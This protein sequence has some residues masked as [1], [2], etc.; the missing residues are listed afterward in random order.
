MDRTM[1]HKG[2]KNAHLEEIEIGWKQLIRK[3]EQD[4]GDGL[5]LQAVLFLI[6][7]QELG[8]GNKKYTKDQKLEVFHVA[9]CTLLEPYGYYTF[10]GLDPDGY[11][12]WK[13]LENLPSLTAGQQMLLMKQAI[14]DY[15]SALF[16]EG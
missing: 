9:I 11:P 6:G 13:Q 14:L 1:R 16:Q 4:F 3:L 10:E 12:H 15:F 8:K 7:I 5:D 2:W